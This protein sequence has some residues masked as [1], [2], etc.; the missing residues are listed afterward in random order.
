MDVITF[1]P[2]CLGRRRPVALRYKLRYGH[3]SFRSQSWEKHVAGWYVKAW[4]IGLSCDVALHGF[5][6]G[7]YTCKDFCVR[8]QA[9]SN[10]TF[11]VEVQWKKIVPRKIAK[12][13][14]T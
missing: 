11:Y 9:A 13:M 12:R 1:P 14:S 8:I 7:A 4:I 5:L 6:D 2:G 3:H 10:E